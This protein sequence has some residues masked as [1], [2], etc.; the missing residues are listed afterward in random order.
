MNSSSKRSHPPLKTEETVSH[1]Q[2]NNNVKEEHGDPASAKPLVYFAHGY[3]N[4]C[5]EQSQ[6][7]VSE[8]QLLRNSSAADN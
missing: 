7:T 8:E 4:G 6:K 5:A 1:R 2:T 3:C